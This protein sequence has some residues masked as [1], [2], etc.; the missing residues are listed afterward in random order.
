MH[1]SAWDPCAAGQP[2]PDLIVLHEDH[3]SHIQLCADVATH[4][5]GEIRSSG[6]RAAIAS[7]GHGIRWRENGE[8]GGGIVPFDIEGDS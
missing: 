5:V 6:T 1:V 7:V 8:S 4:V 3:V 2:D